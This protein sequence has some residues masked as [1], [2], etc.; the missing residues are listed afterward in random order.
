MMGVVLAASLLLELG[1]LG[2][3]G[4][5]DFVPLWTSAVTTLPHWGDLK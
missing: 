2:C 4:E 1:Q 3:F 5:T